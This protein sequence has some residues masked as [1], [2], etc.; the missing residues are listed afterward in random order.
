MGLAGAVGGVLFGAVGD[1]AGLRIALLAA[2]TLF[3]ASAILMASGTGA[4][5]LVFAAGCFGA[6]FFPIFGL[7]PAYAGKTAQADLTPAIC[8]LVECSLGLGG[9]LGS[10][11]G[12]LSPHLA[13][14]F[15]PMY[16]SAGAIAAFMVCLA[17]LLPRKDNR[18][19]CD[20]MLVSE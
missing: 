18:P 4:G 19:A 7:L 8:G 16:V 1:R 11:L 13:G 9:V 17:S 12:G 6:S 2:T 20:L 3:S 10:F 15:R 14:S 5:S